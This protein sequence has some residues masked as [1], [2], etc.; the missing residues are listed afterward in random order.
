MKLFDKLINTLYG[1]QGFTVK[2]SGET[3]S[4][5]YAVAIDSLHEKIVEWKADKAWLGYQLQE[6]I[7]TNIIPLLNGAYLGVWLEVHT[8]T[9]YFDLSEVLTTE[10]QATLACIKR[11]QLAYYDIKNNKTVYI[12][13]RQA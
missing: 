7:R 9:L 3:P 6:Y 4:T 10:K 8:N 13:D 1:G 11:Q 5:G 2:L 12:E